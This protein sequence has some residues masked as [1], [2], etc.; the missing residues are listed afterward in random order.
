MIAP[1]PA[2]ASMQRWTVPSPPQTNIRSA[3]RVMASRAHAAA[4]RLLLT[5]YQSGS[6][7]PSAASTPRSPGRPP[8]SL[9]R[10]CATTATLGTFS[11]PTPVYQG[12][13]RGN[14]VRPAVIG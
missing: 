11:L 8:P 1:V 14:P 4:W 7:T 12:D 9:L 3:P 5:S 13:T 6:V 2:T 10:A